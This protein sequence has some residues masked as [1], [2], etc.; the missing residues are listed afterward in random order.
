MAFTGI[1]SY[2]E[3]RKRGKYIYKGA[4]KRV[5]WIITDCYRTQAYYNSG[6]WICGMPLTVMAKCHTEY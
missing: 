2:N 3:V 4:I 6:E 5:N 1:N